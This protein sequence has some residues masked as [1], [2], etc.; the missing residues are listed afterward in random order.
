MQ[1][2]RIRGLVT[3]LGAAALAGVTVFGAVPA[4]AAVTATA[5]TASCLVSPTITLVAPQ[6]VWQAATITVDMPATVN[7]GEAFDVVITPPPI[8]VPNKMSIA[9][10]AS[11]SRIKID[12]MVPDN[13]TFLGAEVVAGTGSGLS[14]VAPNVLRVNDS[15]AV[16]ANGAI[17]RLSGNNATIGNGP[18]SSTSSEGGI[19]AKA[20]SGESTT[21]QLPAIRA[22][23]KA[24]NSGSI[25]LKVRTAGAA[26]EWNKD[27][28]FLTFLA[29]GTALGIAAWA[30]TRCTPRDSGTSELNSGAAA[31]ASTHILTN[32]AQSQSTTTLSA[33]DAVR[34]GDTVTLSAN[35]SPASA[36]TVVFS[37]DGAPLGDPVTVVNG[38]ATTTHV[39]ATD[40]D[41]S[42][43][44]AY[45]GTQGV[46]GS[47]SP[48]KTISVTTEEEPE[49]PGD[50]G[51]TGSSNGSSN[52]QR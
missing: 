49:N 31:V 2:K 14:G 41:Y 22:H 3:P 13:A 28:N 48:A 44:A 40:G 18:S 39:F 1:K 8:T 42:V 15:G 43:T 47:T 27:T 30:P 20:T 36:G 21:F 35:V 11:I 24:G 7:A 34:N 37:L 5:F 38:V 52:R 16:D 17:L 4:Q 45:S 51:G 50:G 12:T 6:E 32:G 10:V 9:T 33:P 26:G 25:E 19:I 29:K 46:T 23:L